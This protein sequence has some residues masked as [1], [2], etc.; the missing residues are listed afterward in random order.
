MVNRADNPGVR[1]PPPLLYAAAVI[2]GWLLNRAW[3]LPIGGGTASLIIGWLLAGAWAILTASSVGLFRRRQ[4]SMIPI[5]PANVLVITGPYK[6]T[7]N[8]MYVALA[9]LTV[10]FAFFLNTWWPVVLLVPTL[11]AVQHFVIVPEE[12]YPRRRFGAEYDEYVRRVRRW[13]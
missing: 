5:R 12:N 8:P 3:P 11:V 9:L 6:M 2:G 1:L 10:A 13:L 4:T 7:R